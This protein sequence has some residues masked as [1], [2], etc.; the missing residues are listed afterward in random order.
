MR[1][2]GGPRA[3]V[4]KRAVEISADQPN[5]GGDRL[6]VD[7]MFAMDKLLREF[8]SN[9]SFT[10]KSAYELAMERLEKQAPTLHISEE[11]KR[12]IAEIDSTFKAR[13]AEREVFLKDQIA[14]AVAGGQQEDIEQLQK[15][16]A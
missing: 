7:S 14:K 1:R 12:E 11:Q 3:V 4:D 8:G 16:L 6:K 13:I 15:Q 10:M 5:H 9:P 2:N